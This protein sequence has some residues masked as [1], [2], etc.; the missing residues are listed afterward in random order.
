MMYKLNKE[1]A[2]QIKKDYSYIEGKTYTVMGKPLRVAAIVVNE[3]PD[4]DLCNVTVD[5]DII[6]S[7]FLPSMII[8]LFFEEVGID[9]NLANYGTPMSE[10]EE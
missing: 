10:E 3:L 9:F 1:Q 8:E 2:L 5:F 7:N 4:S 6:H